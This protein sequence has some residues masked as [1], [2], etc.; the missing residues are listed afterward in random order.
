MVIHLSKRSQSSVIIDYFK[1]HTPLSCIV[2]EDGLAID[3]STVYLAPEDHHLFIDCGVMLVRK[4]AYE[5]HYRPSIDILFRSAAA[6]YG[7]CV[8][9]I[10]LTGLLDDGVSGMSAIKRSGGHVPGTGAY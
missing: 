3:N 4:G 2:A 8:T 1:K 5:N 10:I 7:S 6:A 9:G